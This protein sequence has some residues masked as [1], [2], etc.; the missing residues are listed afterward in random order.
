MSIL[1]NKTQGQYVIVQMAMI[2][3]ARLKLTDRGLLLTLLSLPDN[4]NL[5]IRGLAAILPDG[6][7]AIE[8]S[9]KRLEALGYITRYQDRSNAGTYGG[10]ILEIHETPIEQHEENAQEISA[11]GNTDKNSK[12]HNNPKTGHSSVEPLTS[13]AVENVDFKGKTPYPEN[14]VTE[15]QVSDLPCPEKRYPDNRYPEKRYPDNRPQSINYKSINNKSNNQVVSNER[16]SDEDYNALINIFDKELVDRQIQKIKER[17]YKGC[18][19]YATIFKWCSETTQVDVSRPQS[20]NRFNNFEQRQY[21]YDQ[22][23]QQLLARQQ[24]SN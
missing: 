10:T 23:E 4:W 5:S 11:K 3:D 12:K 21:D 20:K 8:A 24:A 18:M 13:D 16:L 17:N 9:M 6:K 7:S 22:L 1:R 14:Q 15:E 19:N 2:K